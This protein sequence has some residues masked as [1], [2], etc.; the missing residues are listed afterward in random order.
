MSSRNPPE[1]HPEGGRFPPE[2]PKFPQIRHLAG[3]EGIIKKAPSR[4]LFGRLRHLQGQ[5]SAAQNV[6]MQML[7]GL[8]GV[9]AAVAHYPVAVFQA[10][11]PGNAGDDLKD[12]GDDGAVFRGDGRAVSNVCL[13]YH[14]NVG[15]RLGGNIPEGEDQIVLV[16]LGRGDVP[17]DDLAE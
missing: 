11:G 16:Y 10:F 13:G 9:G 12:V 5:R 8:T 14:Q 15:G 3:N 6:E 2:K 17:C 7:Y 4:S 1:S